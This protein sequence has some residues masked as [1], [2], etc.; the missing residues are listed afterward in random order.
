MAQPRPLSPHLQVYRPQLTS[1]MSIMHRASGVVLATGSLL[2][3][4]FL[5]ALAMGE[6]A[7]EP[8][9]LALHHPVG[10]FVL[11][12]YSL[13]LVYHGLNGIRHL[14][15]DLSIGLEIRHVYQS[16]YIVLGLTF[17]ITTALWLLA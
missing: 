9:V 1:V 15:W 2:L 5:T 10:R 16:G 4:I 12:G 8:L 13:A 7:F 14:A 6:K 3:A 17:L 11:F